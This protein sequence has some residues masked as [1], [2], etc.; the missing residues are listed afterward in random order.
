MQQMVDLDDGSAVKLTI[1]R[2]LTPKART[3]DK[4]GIKPDIEI[5]RTVEDYN[6]DLDP[7][8]DRALSYFVE[9]K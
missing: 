4:E 3:I 9:G 2:W 6:N 1:A 8:L 7:Q 5:E